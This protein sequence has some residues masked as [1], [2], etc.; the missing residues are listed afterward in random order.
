MAYSYQNRK[1]VHLESYGDLFVTYLLFRYVKALVVAGKITK[2]SSQEE[3][4]ESFPKCSNMISPY[5]KENSSGDICRH[6]FLTYFEFFIVSR[7][8]N[9]PNSEVGTNI[10]CLLHVIDL[11]MQR[12]GIGNDLTGC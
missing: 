2:P 12:S 8:V 7:K 3:V 11:A 4:G 6:V 5:L 9:V 10:S 1:V